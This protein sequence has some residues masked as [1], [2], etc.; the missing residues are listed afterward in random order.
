MALRTAGYHRL[1]VRER[2]EP[3]P[4]LLRHGPG[5][6]LYAILDHVVDGYEVA[7]Q[8]VDIDIQEVERQVFSHENNNPA[9]RIYAGLGF[10][11]RRTLYVLDT[12]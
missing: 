2:I 10:R 9:E 3:R 8:G 11:R 5:M 12:A 4:D 6:A 1:A 7:A